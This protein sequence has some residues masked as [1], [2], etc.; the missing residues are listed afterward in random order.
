MSSRDAPAWLADLQARFGAT[1][2]TP[3]DRASG[4]LRAT[5]AAYDAALVEQARGGPKTSGAERLAVYNRQYWFRLFGVLQTAFPLTTRLL[6]HWTFNDHASR[7]LLAHPPHGWDVGR[8]ADGFETFLD[9]ETPGEH[10]AAGD[11]LVARE[12]L[13]EAARIDAAFMRV[14][15]APEILPYRPSA[16]DA[17]RLLDARLVPSPAAALVKESWPLLELRKQA[18][19]DATEA[20]VALP[21]RLPEARWWAIVRRPEGLGHLPLEARE[22]ELLD[23]LGRHTVR[24]A[25]ARLEAACPAEERGE[26]PVKTQAWLARSVTLGFWAGAG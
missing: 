3:L 14:L 24:D 4:T 1:I 26:L 5:P 16:S 6:G 10:V 15:G 25:L 8:A 2:R 21:A 11:R 18:R 7:F 22:A 12:A 23:L 9:E 17:P 20:P 19:D 13:V